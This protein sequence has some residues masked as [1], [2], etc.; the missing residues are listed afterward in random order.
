MNVMRFTVID[1]RGAIS[2]VAPCEALSALVA[3]CADNPARYEA[4]LER[5]GR[6]S[7]KLES[8]VLSGLA[9]FDEH[10]GEGHHEAIHAALRHMRPHEVPPF[11]VVD[12]ETRR[13]SLEAV[14]AGVVLFNLLDR[15][16][17]Q[18]QNSYDEVRRR[19]RVRVY[20]GTRWAGEV[21]RYE[22]P[23]SWDIVP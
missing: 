17:V 10:N 6:F 14:K 3:A 2:F 11:R 12:D 8:Y 19:G 13:A 4:L 5:A 21:H 22:L 16:I 9:V 23:S 1:A 15:R 7:P 18:V 20:Q